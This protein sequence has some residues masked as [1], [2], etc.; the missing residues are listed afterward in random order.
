AFTSL[1][2][3]LDLEW[4]KEAYQRTRKDG[5]VGVDGVSAEE[6]EQDLE[7]NLRR[8]LD[9]VKSGTYQA[10]PVRRG[11]IPKGGST[12]ETRSLG[13]PAREEKVLQRAVVMLLGPIYERE[14]LDSPDGCRCGRSAPQ[15][16]ET[17]R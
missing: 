15:A 12:T 7:G 11:H 8:L 1:A 6:Y 2:Y 14:F 10:P 16:L 3:L 13:V 5:A 17:F 4:L 9:R